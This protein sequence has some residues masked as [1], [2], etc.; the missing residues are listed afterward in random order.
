[1]ASDPALEA[2]VQALTDTLL[3]TLGDALPG[4]YLYG[5][6]TAGG[7]RPQSDVDLFAISAQPMSMPQRSALSRRLAPLSARRLRP[8][9]WRPAEVTVVASSDVRPWRDSPPMDFLMGE[10]MRADLDAGGLPPRV[11]ANPD[12]AVLISMV[13]DS[14]RVLH[15]APPAT[16]LDPVPRAALVRGMVESL[17]SLLRDLETD[18]RNVLLTLARIW[19]TLATG[20]I[21]SKDVA[22]AW[23]IA[24]L[25]EADGSLLARARSAYMEGWDES[26]TGETHAVRRL[27]AT[28]TA[29]IQ[30]VAR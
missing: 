13:R 15:G 3:A 16:L 14:G 9:D 5:S 26:W 10:W 30:D 27:A 4:V 25:P 17:G 20:E 12:L 24:Q 2:Q 8:A 29:R 21:R 1:M 23:C 7:L 28:L 6:A 11:A 18:T 19:T 22:A